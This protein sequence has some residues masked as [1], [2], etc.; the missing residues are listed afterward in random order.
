MAKLG[1][2]QLDFVEAFAADIRAGAQFADAL[3][4]HVTGDS[5]IRRAACI[6][7]LQAVA[8]LSLDEL[9]FL[10]TWAKQQAV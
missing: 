6:Q 9:S 7:T 4:K 10:L 2:H 1:K 8:A 3:S 5:R